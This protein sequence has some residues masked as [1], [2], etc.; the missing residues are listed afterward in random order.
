MGITSLLNVTE[1]RET[2]TFWKINF[3]EVKLVR[4]QSELIQRENE[5]SYCL[6]EKKWDI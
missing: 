4:S 6:K 1:Y 3:G 2:S 5:I